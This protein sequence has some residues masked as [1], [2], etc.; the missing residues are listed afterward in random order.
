MSRTA[1]ETPRG[2]HPC[3][4]ESIHPYSGAEARPARGAAPPGAAPTTQSAH[5]TPAGAPGPFLA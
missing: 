4:D 2:G 3:A 1:V 5:A